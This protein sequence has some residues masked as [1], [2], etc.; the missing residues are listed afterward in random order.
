MQNGVELAGCYAVTAVDSFENE[1]SQS[2]RMC[3]DVCV[4]YELPNVF[5]PNGDGINDVYLS[6]NLNDAIKKVDMKIFNRFGLLVYGTNDPNINWNGKIKSS[7]RTVSPGVYY[8]ICDVYEPRIVGEVIRTITGFI[9]V[10]T[11]EGTII[12]NE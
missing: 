11:G 5:T 8:Y 12:S 10:Y 2:S 7:D 6:K 1:S 9:H 4:L 3:V